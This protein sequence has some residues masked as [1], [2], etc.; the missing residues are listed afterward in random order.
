RIRGVATN[1]PFLLALLDE[2]DFVAGQVTTSFIET[3]PHLLTAR[4]S[5]N[6]GTRLLTYLGDVT[7]NRPHGDPPELA[8]PLCKLPPID[9][10]SRPPTGS[11]HR[12]LPLGPEEFACWLRTADT[13]GVTDTTFRDAHQSLLATRVRSRDLVAVGPHVARMTPQLLSLE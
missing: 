4:R 9:L 1:I 13:V 12:L 7:V 6:P 11:R 2:P 5:A 8:D 10:D 3:R